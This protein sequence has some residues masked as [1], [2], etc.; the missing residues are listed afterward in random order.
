MP[1][2]ATCNSIMPNFIFLQGMTNN[3]KF[4]V[5]VGET[6]LAVLQLLVLS[7]KKNRVGETQKQCLVYYS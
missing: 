1:V 5:S 6:T 3:V 4:I 2:I 7:K